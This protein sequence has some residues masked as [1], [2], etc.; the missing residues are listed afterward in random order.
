M[1]TAIGL[2]KGLT[3]RQISHEMFL[4]ER[5]V[6]GIVSSV[7]TKLGMTSRTQAAVFIARAL[8][9][10]ENPA[11]GGYRSS[12]FPDLIA[13][14]IAALLNCT[15]EARTAPPTDAER[16]EAARR[17]ADALVATRTGLTSRRPQLSRD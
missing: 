7:L 13:E 9:H 15:S 11:D 2:G 3:N 14:V 6:K 4:A 17:L 10:H 12:P 8:N 1:N 16:A 5:T